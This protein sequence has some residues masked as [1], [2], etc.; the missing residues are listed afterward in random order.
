LSTPLSYICSSSSRELAQGVISEGTKMSGLH[1]LHKVSVLK[2][3]KGGTWGVLCN[4][5]TGRILDALA[6]AVSAREHKEGVEGVQLVVLAPQHGYHMTEQ[7]NMIESKDSEVRAASGQTV[8]CLNVYDSSNVQEGEGQNSG[9]FL[10]LLDAEQLDVVF[11]D[12]LDVGSRIYTFQYTLLLLVRGVFAYAST[13]K[14]EASVRVVV[15]DRPNPIGRGVCG[16]MMAGEFIGKSFVSMFPLPLRP[17]LTLGELASLFWAEEM[18]EYS[19]DVASRVHLEV[20]RHAPQE[21]EEH[22]NYMCGL[23]A[24][25]NP[26]PNL[27]SLTCAQVYYAMVVVEGTSLSEGRGTT[28]PFLTVGAPW[29]QFAG[30]VRFIKAH[31]VSRDWESSYDLQPHTFRPTFDKYQGQEC[32]GLKIIPKHEQALPQEEEEKHV[33]VDPIFEFSILLLAYCSL[34][35]SQ[36]FALRDPKEGYEY[37]Y[38]HY[39]VDLI[40]GTSAFRTQV[41]TPLM[42]LGGSASRDKEAADIM[43]VMCQL[44]AGTDQEKKSLAEWREHT[45]PFRIY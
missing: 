29:F 36:D 38:E 40:L 39:A 9:S 17:G 37:N 1:A 7:M 12:L 45:K 2:A 35:H 23:R 5:S 20:V 31:A 11:V 24:H 43:S 8:R 28:T 25:F 3:K 41:F 18:A 16:P 19:S 33:C 15:V 26:S 22:A 34:Y 10:S 14:D 30:L 42:E 44:I 27:N 13:H 21:S 6:D 32:H 4:Q